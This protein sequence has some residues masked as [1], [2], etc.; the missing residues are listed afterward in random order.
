M[1]EAITDNP[2]Y[3]DAHYQSRGRLRDEETAREGI[4]EAPLRQGDFT[5]RAKADPSLEN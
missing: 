1:L 5:G 4:G 3:A 2:D